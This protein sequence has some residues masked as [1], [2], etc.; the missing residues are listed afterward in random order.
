L[1]KETVDQVKQ[2]V[3]QELQRQMCEEWLGD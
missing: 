1:P 2:E 3:K